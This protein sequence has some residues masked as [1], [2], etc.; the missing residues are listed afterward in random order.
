MTA[1]QTP[2]KPGPTALNAQFERKVRLAQWA[3]LFERLWPRLW[4]LFG[5]ALLFLLASLLGLWSQLPEITHKSVL[6]VFGLIGLA[7]LVAAIRTPMPT[8]DEAVRRLEARSGVPHRPAST[9]EDTVTM[10]GHDPATQSIWAAHKARLEGLLGGM[11]VGSP[12]PR[13]DKHDPFALRALLLLGLAVTLAVVGDSARDRLWAAFRFGP[14]V[15]AANARL[16]AW[17]TPPP[18]TGRAP[19][20]LADGAQGGTIAPAADGKP[21]EIPEKSLLI[22]R[23]AGTGLGELTLELTD[24]DGKI[25]K[26]PVDPKAAEKAADKAKTASGAAQAAAQAPQSSDSAEARLEMTRSGTIRAYSGRTEVARWAFQVIPD[27]PPSIRLVKEPERSLRGSVKLTYKM[28]DD[29]GVAS[30]EARFK[31][32]PT[33]AADPATAWARRP[34]LRGPRRPLFKLPTFAL[35]L[36]KDPSKP[37]VV[38]SSHEVGSHPLA[39]TK[40]QMTLV[41][42]DHAG[43]TGQSKSV[44]MTLPSRAFR[45]PLARAVVEQRRFLAEDSRS[46]LQVAKVLDALTM[47]PEGYIKDSRAYLGLRDA[48]HRLMRDRSREGLKSVMDQLWH[49][50]L[51]LEDGMNKT[52]A[53]KRLRDIQEKLSEALKNGAS[54]EEIQ[55]LMQELRQALAEFLQQLAEG[56]QP[57]EGQPQQGGQELSQQDLDRMLQNLENMARGGA[58]DQA[59]DMLSQLRDLLENL[60]PG[61]QQAQ[62]Q[63]GQGNQQMM[64]MMDQFG[65]IIGKQQQLLDDTFSE[66]QG[67]GQQGQQGQQGQR[68]GKPGQGQPGQQGQRRPGQGQPGQGQPGQEPGQ[69]QGQGQAQN[70]QPG[71]GQGLGERQGN[72]GERLGK[73]QQGLQG[74]GAQ[75]PDQLKEAEQ[76]MRNAQEALERG[77]LDQATRDQ[78]KALEQM[79]QG[80][81]QL[82]Q[83]MQKRRGNR[84]GRNGPAGDAPRDPLGRPRASEGPEFGTDVKVPDAIEM[85]TAREILEELRRRQS[86]PSRPTGEIDYIERLLRRF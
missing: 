77:D 64:Q 41:A 61:T 51:R 40:V 32:V 68:G 5:L 35:K 38:T 28:E 13:T 79:R 81:Q 67:E 8:R 60:Q 78:G 71:Q 25:V 15:N 86:D 70:G 58:R 10:S 50:A 2:P 72:L 7:G 85:Q 49:V 26:P 27:Q 66:N 20:L 82:A 56:Q 65:D 76:S 19:I 80:A 37:T 29:Y 31:R 16:D 17:V 69:G 30:A 46:R 9:Y 45:K 47:E 12:E 34:D 84:V 83:E 54:D 6:A 1:P 33:P 63:G 14:V 42:R 52:E 53:E 23:T 43:N 62:G 55:A 75:A 39:G 57:G 24:A 74:L 22:V 59:Q 48:R 11:R 36:P 44:E 73:L 3:G 21:Q 4:V 18:Y